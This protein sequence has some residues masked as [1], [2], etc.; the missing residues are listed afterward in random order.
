MEETTRRKFLVKGIAGIAG[1]LALGYAIPLAGYALLP[2]FRKRE[3]PWSEVGPADKLEVNRP[4]ELELVVSE[5][6][7]WMKTNS[8]RSIWS[9][10]KPNGQIVVFS[11]ICP[12][13]GCAYRWE[14]QKR[15]FHCPCHNSV[16]A[17]DGHL[18]SGPAP[19]GLD[20]LPE[21]VKK[22]DLYVRYEVFKVGIPEKEEI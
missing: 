22:G 20:T 12:H 18:L 17:L 2:A 13:L 19:R 8:V 11:P 14:E 4:K 21:M 15:V 10:K 1:L 6:S 5:K 9:Y 7:G 3:E 16:Y